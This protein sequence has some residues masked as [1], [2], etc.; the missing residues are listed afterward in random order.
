MF[1]HGLKCL[2]NTR[3][4]RSVHAPC[5]L[6]AW[7]GANSSSLYGF[8]SVTQFRCSS[9]SSSSSSLSCDGPLSP[10]RAF[11]CILHTSHPNRNLTFRLKPS[12]KTRESCSGTSDNKAGAAAGDAEIKP[13][14][15]PQEPSKPNHNHLYKKPNTNQL[16]P[17][18]P[19]FLWV[20]LMNCF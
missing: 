15:S 2:V 19:P 11:V 4:L 5:P 16:H 6:S 20:S 8:L 14:S 3:F 18:S 17:F 13:L 12:C 1:A 10:R 7:S 9:S